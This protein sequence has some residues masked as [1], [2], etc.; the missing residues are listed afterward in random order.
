VR[1]RGSDQGTDPGGGHGGVLRLR[2]RRR[3]RRPRRR[4]AECNKNLIYIYFENKETLFT[5]VLERHLLRVY[6][7][8][9]FTPDD[10]P[11]YATRCLISRWHTPI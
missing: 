2:H 1:Q 7:D 3:A 4:T 8:L 11:G 6:E 5:T 10:L 9:A